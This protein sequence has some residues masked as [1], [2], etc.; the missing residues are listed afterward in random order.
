M[1]DNKTMLELLSRMSK[2]ELAQRFDKA[3]EFLSKMAAQLRQDPNPYSVPGGMS[4]RVQMSVRGPD[5]AVRQR[6]DVKG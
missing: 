2:E 1:I 5:G 3:A 6:V 4:N